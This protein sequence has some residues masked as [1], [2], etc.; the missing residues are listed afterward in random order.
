LGIP[1]LPSSLLF[2]NAKPFF[3]YACQA[4]TLSVNFS[5]K[6]EGIKETSIQSP[7]PPEEAIRLS[8]KYI[9]KSYFIVYSI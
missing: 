5:P 3:L 6:N 7:T 8:L 9:S 2:I 1:S 4:L